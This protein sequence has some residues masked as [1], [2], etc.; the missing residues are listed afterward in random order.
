[1]R[2]FITAYGVTRDGEPVVGFDTF[3]CGNGNGCLDTYQGIPASNTE[4]LSVEIDAPG[5]IVTVYADYC[6]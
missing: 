6:G 5:N 1:M 3:F 2:I 4:V